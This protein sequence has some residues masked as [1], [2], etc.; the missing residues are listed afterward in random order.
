NAAGAPGVVTRVLR[1]LRAS[2]AISAARYRRYA[3]S[4]SAAT[5]TLR[6][7]SGTRAAELGAVLEG[8]RTIAVSHQL[9]PS[10]LPALLLTLARNRNWWSAGP[11]LSP[12]Q[13]VE[14]AGSELVW[15]YYPGQGIELQEL[16]SFGKANGLFTAGPGAYPRMLRLLGELLPL[17][18]HRAGGVAWEYFFRFQ[19]AAPPWSSAM[20]QATALQA[21]ARAYLITHRS[22]LLDLGR[23]ALALFAAPP[24]AGAGV[25]TSRGRRYLL[26]SFAPGERVI[27]G[28]LQSLIGLF[29][30]AQVSGDAKAARLFAAGD[31]QARAEL[32]AYDT[33]AWS[34]YEPG[35]ESTLDYHV[36]VTGFAAGLC[37]RTHA[38][39]YCAT[40][41]R[42]DRYLKTPT[43]LSLLT[44][45]VAARRPAALRFRLSKV[46]HVGIVI[47]RGA[48]TV[49]LT[50][51]TYGYGVHRFLLPPMPP[52]GDGV[53][54]AASDLAGNFSRITGTLSVHG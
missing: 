13:R 43:A 23:R 27:N 44:S 18:S 53:R 35:Q 41:R 11:L 19:G 50:S 12:G 38:R 29:D 2:G 46:S 22:S 36:L 9:T 24:P 28:F 10:R 16:G 6:R 37:K 1:R 20:S 51:A 45:G 32:A 52:G 48:H 25:P 26:Y 14:F 39:T 21:L 4:L 15:E 47:T 7:L 40:A 8:L 5:G 49:F 42:F 30:F 31:A 54:L 17:A 34:L 33:G 3:G